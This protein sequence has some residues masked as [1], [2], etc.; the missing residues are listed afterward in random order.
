MAASN[1]PD[2]NREKIIEYEKRVTERL[3]PDLE[4]ALEVRKVLKAERQDY[5]DLASNVQR[6]LS[7][8]GRPSDQAITNSFG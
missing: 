4:K 5:Q 2:A 1:V 3:Q 6:L 7:E 8:V